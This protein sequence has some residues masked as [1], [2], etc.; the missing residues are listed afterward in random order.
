MLW[1][2][3]L[4]KWKTLCRLYTCIGVIFAGTK[5][6]VRIYHI[7][8]PLG[9]PFLVGGFNPFEK[10]S[11]NW[12]IS[13]RFGVKIKNAW[14]HHPEKHLSCHHLDFTDLFVW[15]FAISYI[16]PYPISYGQNLCGFLRELFL[17]LAVPALPSPA[18]WIRVRWSDGPCCPSCFLFMCTLG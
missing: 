13:P 4:W 15:C 1:N 12:I 16:H 5:K 8:Y 11:S 18:G 7:L 14:N 10:Y 2:G 6:H 3:W 17:K 9:K